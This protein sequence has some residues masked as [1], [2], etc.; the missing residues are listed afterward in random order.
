MVDVF[1]EQPLLGNPLP[2]VID[3]EG[4]D[5]DDM[6]RITRWMN[7]SETTFLLPPTHAGADYRVRIFTLERELPFAGHP[8]LG[9]CHVWLNNGGRPRNA[10]RILQ[11]CGAGL[12][13]IRPARDVQGDLL[14]FAAP[15]LLRSG[16]VDDDE[17]REVARVL[18]ISTDDMVAIEWAD[19]GPGWIGVLLDS[20]RAVLDLRPAGSHHRRIE[21][22]VVGP[23]PDGHEFEYELRA[24][25][26]DQTGSLR[27]DPVTGSLNAS[28][29]QWLIGSGR[30]VPPY[31]AHQGTCVGRSG[32]I[33]IARDDE[34]IWVGGR[35]TALIRGN[36]FFRRPA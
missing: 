23:Y 31:R 8:T 21:I 11:E 34:G 13:P 18:G 5:S 32:T 22:G 30:A 15:P 16:P 10:G 14:S 24:L 17:A 7:Q 12:I 25:Y 28:V 3:A 1:S 9:T 36:C 6:M 35:V 27:E 20:A 26:S 19:N 33:Y 29:A 4:L 2:V